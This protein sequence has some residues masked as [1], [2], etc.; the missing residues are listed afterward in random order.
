VNLIARVR[1]A[2]LAVVPGLAVLAA[3]PALSAGP[4]VQPPAAGSEFQV[5]TYTTGTQGRPSVSKDGNGN[6]VAVWESVGDGSGTGIKGRLYDQAGVPKT[7]EFQ[8][9]TYTSGDQ[10]A[11][12]VAMDGNGNFIVVWN[13][14]G[15]DGSGNAVEARR[16]DGTGAPLDANEFQVNTFTTGQQQLPAV[17]ADLTG[18]FTVA[19]DSFGQD[20]SGSGIYAR[21]YNAAGSPLTAEIPVNTTTVASQAYPDVA[22]DFAGSFTVVWM[23]D[24]QDGSNNGIFGRRFDGSGAPLTAEF[25][26]NTFTT[27]QQFLPT[28]SGDVFGNFMVVWMSDAQDG[29]FWGVY[30]RRFDINGAP[31]DANEFQVNVFTAGSQEK[32][33]VTTAAGDSFVVVYESYNEDGSDKGIFARTYDHTGASS[34]DVFQVNSYTTGAQQ[35]AA[36]GADD[37]GRF[38]VVWQSDGQDG[39]GAGIFAQ[40]FGTNAVLCPDGDGDGDGICDNADNCTEI[41]NADQADGDVDGHGDLCDDC[42]AVANAN[43]LDTDDDGRGDLCDNCPAAANADQV[44]RDGDGRGDACD[45][46]LT[47]PTEGG[48]FDCS[49]PKNLR[50]TITWAPGPYDRFRVEIAWN[51]SFVVGTKITSGGTLLKTTAYM[52]PGRTFLKAC[53]KALQNSSLAA[54]SLYVR[55]YGKD[56]NATR[57]D[58]GKTTYSDVVAATVTP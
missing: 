21:R 13:S 44:D 37:L 57:R 45:V 4:L 52:P 36:V 25:A 15:Q 40:R 26:V 49:D 18:N 23:G 14:F 17:S 39:S 51:P 1:D 30:G 47:S 28:V 43:Q 19:W 11:P 54:P 5:N 6:F 20:G 56:L 27:G 10:A 35:Y 48:T 46:V 33:A 22:Q 34:S 2:A 31:L 16:Y 41:A 24:L 3:A 7:G 29:D 12:D 50:P 53:T 58:P 9:N 32:P 55:V 42:P 8:I 38:V